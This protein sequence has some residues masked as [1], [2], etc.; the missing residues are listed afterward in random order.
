MKIIMD[1]CSKVSIKM[2]MQNMESTPGRMEIHSKVQANT[3]MVLTA[4]EST[5][6]MVRLRKLSSKMANSLNMSSN[7]RKELKDIN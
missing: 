4:S 6:R 2:E 3:I 5:P 7:F 1:A